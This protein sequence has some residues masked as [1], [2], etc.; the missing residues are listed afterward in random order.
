WTGRVLRD[1]GETI[2]SRGILSRPTRRGMMPTVAA[3][4]PAS[5]AV[6]GSGTGEP[7]SNQGKGAVMQR[8]IVLASVL[9]FGFAFLG[10]AL[11][12]VLVVPTIVDAQAATN[13]SAGYVLV[14]SDGSERATLVEVGEGARFDLKQ[15]GTER[16]TL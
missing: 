4:V 1:H 12:F 3:M 15:G 10:S 6:T 9:S 13:R 8:T 7:V 5:G 14:A 16:V 11:A 2:T